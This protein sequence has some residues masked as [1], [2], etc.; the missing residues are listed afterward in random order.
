M[1]PPQPVLDKRTKKV[2]PLLDPYA[3]KALDLAHAEQYGSYSPRDPFNL[4]I[5][6]LRSVVL[7]RSCGEALL[8]GERY[9]DANFKCQR[10]SGP[11]NSVEIPR[12]GR[13]HH[14]ADQQVQGLYLW[15][16]RDDADHYWLRK[17]KCRT[18]S[19][20]RDE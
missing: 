12:L 11:Q 17:G 3:E 18:V 1:A 16:N 5:F 8:R 7:S 4:G 15:R 9:P 19:V 10:L 13:G 14:D 6:S 20:S 2:I